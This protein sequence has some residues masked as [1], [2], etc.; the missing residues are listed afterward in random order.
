[1]PYLSDLINKPVA[2]ISGE[3]I[4]TVTDL[5]ASIHHSTIHHPVITALLVKRPKNK[6]IIIPF[7]DVVVFISPAIPISK[8]IEDVVPYEPLE[9]DI[10]LT[11]D[12]W[13]KQIIDTDGLRVVRVNDVELAQVEGN[14]YVVNVDVGGLGLLRRLGLAKVAQRFAS[15]VQQNVPDNVIGWDNV[16][17]LQRGD[18]RLKVPIAKI[19]DLHPA[20]IAEIISDLSR[21][22]SNQILESLDVETLA[23]ALE[24]VETDFQAS[25][26][27][28][29]SDDKVAD[30]LEEMSPDDAADLLAE[31]SQE[32]RDELLEQME[33]EAAEDVRGL[34]AYPEDSAGGIMTTDYVSIP[35]DLTTDDAIRTLRET[36]NEAETIFYVYVVDNEEHLI[37]VIS[38][39]D[40]IFASPST[41]I[42][43]YM[44]T[45]VVS[46][47]V[48]ESQ[49]EVAQLVSKYN[50]LAIPV[51]DEGRHLVGIVTSDDALDKIIPTAWKKRLPRIYH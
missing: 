7:T 27:E 39:K 23:D 40:L 33:D 11:R 28:N 30:I 26:V 51:V 38:L 2:D 36:G 42:L 6:Q 3:R 17:L 21:S 37:G 9:D 14:F 32:R 31:M 29:M 12:V 18:M 10:L 24:E 34:L 25:L 16:E 4:G 46:V 20:D 19:A 48:D 8:N 47:Q 49:D 50:L 45:R 13:D 43:E 41:K 35:A 44:H 1:M 22:Q 5:V 15:T